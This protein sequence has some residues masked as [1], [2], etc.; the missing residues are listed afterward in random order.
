MEMMRGIRRVCGACIFVYTRV[1]ACE[2]ADT[3]G[4]RTDLMGVCI[5]AYMRDV[6]VCVYYTAS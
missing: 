4:T 1:C 6:Y 3:R 5:Y 2:A